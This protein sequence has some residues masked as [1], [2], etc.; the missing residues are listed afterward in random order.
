MKR[1]LLL[2]VCLVCFGLLIYIGIKA[3]IPFS[4]RGLLIYLGIILMFGNPTIYYLG[5]A[6][7]SFCGHRVV[8]Q[9]ISSH[10]SSGH[11]SLQSDD[12]GSSSGWHC[13]YAYIDKNNKC[14]IGRIKT[15]KQ[16][17]KTLLIKYWG[18]FKWASTEVNI[19][20]EEYDKYAWSNIVIKEAE[21]KAKKYIKKINITAI[22]CF[23]ISTI[24]I[25]IGGTML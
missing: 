12:F 1:I 23:L 17:N 15:A 10:Y 22:L 21:L 25:I 3:L 6:I 20:Q 24:I 2:V 11:M 14:K 16:P 5:S 18:M 7:V 8:G 13:T 9:V 19:S 4:I